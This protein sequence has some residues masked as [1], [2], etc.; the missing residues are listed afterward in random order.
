MIY[1]ICIICLLYIQYIY[2]IYIFNLGTEKDR[3]ISVWH[4]IPRVKWEHKHTTL[5]VACGERIIFMTRSCSWPFLPSGRRPL[6][7]KVALWSYKKLA[8]VSSCFCCCFLLPSC[9]CSWPS[10]L[11]SVSFVPFRRFFYRCHLARML[12][13]LAVFVSLLPSLWLLLFALIISCPWLIV[14]FSLTRSPLPSAGSAD[15]YI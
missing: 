10:S 6:L 8:T 15:I 13:L 2:N 1:I 5:L 4:C 14:M 3:M 12:L 7:P 11:R 9:S